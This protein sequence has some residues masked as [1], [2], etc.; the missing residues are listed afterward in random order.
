MLARVLNSELQ[1]YLAGN[2]V[3]TKKF[4]DE[5]LEACQGMTKIVYKAT[6]IGIPPPQGGGAGSLCLPTE[7]FDHEVAASPIYAA[8]I[9]EG[10]FDMPCFQYNQYNDFYENIEVD[11]V[12]NTLVITLEM[13]YKGT[14]PILFNSFQSIKETL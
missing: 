8:T 13:Q 9:I 5:P 12:D 2:P 11:V 10:L 4:D 1:S 14:P 3:N 7:L 6:Q